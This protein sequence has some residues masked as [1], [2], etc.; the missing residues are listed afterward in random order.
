MISHDLPGRSN[1][2]VKIGRIPDRIDHSPAV[3]KRFIH[4]GCNCYATSEIDDVK[5]RRTDASPS[6]GRLPLDTFLATR[7]APLQHPAHPAPRRAV[8]R[9]A[10]AEEMKGVEWISLG[11]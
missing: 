10:R 11:Y 4:H 7:T 8:E 6:A 2:V 3:F 1:Q 9:T 5:I